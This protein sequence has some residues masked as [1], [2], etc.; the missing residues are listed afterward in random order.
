MGEPVLGF[1]FFL[2]RR[3]ARRSNSFGRSRLQK[4][5]QVGGG[6]LAS[7][8]LQLRSGGRFC[9]GRRRNCRLI[10]VGL[11]FHLRQPIGFGLE[12]GRGRGRC[13]LFGFHVL[14]PA[15]HCSGG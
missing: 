11:G 9:R 1:Q 12:G 13:L 7:F 3:C 2:G 10:S 6:G 4:I 5:R 15:R 14:Q 8:F